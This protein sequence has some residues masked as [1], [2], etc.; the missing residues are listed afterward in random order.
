[1]K[2]EQQIERDRAT[3]WK[4][5][6]L[7]GHKNE[8]SVVDLFTNP[9]FCKSF[10]ERLGIGNIINASVGGLHETDVE[11]VIGGLTKSKTDLVLTLEDGKK[12][13][14]SIKKSTG[15]QV[16]LISVDR[17]IAGYE[18]QFS[19]TI[20]DDIKDSLYLYFYGHEMTKQLLDRANIVADESD[21]IIRYQ[22]RKGRL[23][24]QSLVNYDSKKADRLLSWFKDNIDNI[25]D[26]CFSKGLA[27]NKSDWADYVWYVNLL[28][29][30]SFD[31]IFSVSDIKDYVLDK[32][33]CI[34]PSTRYGGS[35]IWL[36]F[37][38][39]QW[40]Q[41]QMQFHHSYNNIYDNIKNKL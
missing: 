30:N 29:E 4:H 7:S 9:N 35:T 16:Y 3:G 17:F 23:V 1:M 19:T 40:H 24:W 41:K 10:S 13:N 5:A 21:T 34:Q 20:P 33:D 36:P 22:H 39:V 26:F 12:V 25:A 6:K 31:T 8:K 38:F 27:K 28:G 18:K 14:I 15:G 32:K 2:T 37:G 11:C